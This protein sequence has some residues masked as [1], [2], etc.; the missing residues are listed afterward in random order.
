MSAIGV[1]RRVNLF[2]TLSDADLQDLADCLGKRTFAGDMILFH[3]G[4]P[5]QALYLIESGKVR[6]FA[7]SGAGQEITFDIYGPGECFG[8]TALLDGQIRSA[9]AIALE[10]TV[11]YTLQRDAFL[12]C[13]E[14]HPA[15]ARRA[16]ALLADLAFLDVPARVAAVLVELASRYGI[17]HGGV[18][19]ALHLTQSELASWVCASREM[20]NKVLAAYRDQGLITMEGHMIV[21]ADLAGLKRKTAY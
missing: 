8:E 1:L 14:K 18:E 21:I 5:S 4:S 10:P 12:H 9:G 6:I 11:V 2:E 15:L 16:L 19:I 20:V 17:E 7:L 3:K 13:L